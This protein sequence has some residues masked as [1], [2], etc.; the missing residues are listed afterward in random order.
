[1]L[2]HVTTAD[3]GIRVG[4]YNIHQDAAREYLKRLSSGFDPGVGVLPGSLVRFYSTDV[5]AEYETVELGDPLADPGDNGDFSL[6]GFKNQLIFKTVARTDKTSL[7]G[8]VARGTGG[9][10]ASKTGIAVIH[11]VTQAKVEAGV[12][13]GDFLVANAAN[14]K[15]TLKRLQAG[16]I[17]NTI[18][19]RCIKSLSGG[20][21]IVFVLEPSSHYV[22]TL[23]AILNQGSTA[24]VSVDTMTNPII[25][26][27][28]FL[29]AGESLAASTT[30][31][32]AR[33]QS[34]FNVIAAACP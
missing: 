26:H 19:A 8:V 15:T 25:A 1:M 17:T 3:K 32:I 33:D 4:D 27:D 24:F 20:W 6:D 18:V 31:A 9:T 23:D 2:E 29:G 16:D 13:D 7:V 5:Y 34:R 22:G 12:A 21:A 30:V 11:G 14:N 28:R 10:A